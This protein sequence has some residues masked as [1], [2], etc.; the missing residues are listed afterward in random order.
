MTNQPPSQPRRPRY[1]PG[2]L[3]QL[4]QNAKLVWKLLRDRR[5]PFL[6][7][8]LPVFGIL[9]L[10]FPDFMPG[11]IDDTLAVFLSSYLFIEL[12]PDGVVAELRKDNDPPD[13]SQDD[14]V[15]EA[16]WRDAD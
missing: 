16:E 3:E 6:L 15:V 14:D 10:I 9:Y 7:K 8:F 13:N 5:V 4:A 1:D 11:P 2:I 12:S